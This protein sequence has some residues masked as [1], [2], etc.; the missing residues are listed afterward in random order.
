[1]GNQTNKIKRV[2][3]ILQKMFLAIAWLLPV[4]ISLF[5]LGLNQIHTAVQIPMFQVPSYPLPLAMIL[6]GLALSMIK[7]TCLV[8]TAFSL[9][10]LFSLYAQG[11]IF[12]RQNSQIIRRIAKLVLLYIP[13][14]VAVRTSLVY[15][16]TSR[17]VAKFEISVSTEELGYLLLGGTVLVIAWIMEEA[18]SLKND[19]DMTI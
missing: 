1:M 7:V 17:G 8:A 5:W 10:R 19:F 9:S 14:S 4:G 15:L 3:R 12:T 16:L 6:G 11:F 18:R 2:S 13:I